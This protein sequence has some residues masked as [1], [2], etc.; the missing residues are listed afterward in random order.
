MSIFQLLY[1]SYRSNYFQEDQLANLL[2]EA[3][4]NNEAIKITGLLVYRDGI[5]VQLLEGDKEIVK[6]LYENHISQDERHHSCKILTQADQK[7]RVFP[8][9]SMGVIGKSLVYSEFQPFFELLE[10]EYEESELESPSK[11]IEFLKKF[12]ATD[13]DLESF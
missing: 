2:F 3:R 12:S 1:R 4:K 9:W 8:H 6:N 13:P 7:D 11:M 5:F 10:K